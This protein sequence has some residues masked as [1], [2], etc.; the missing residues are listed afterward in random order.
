MA[1]SEVAAV[2]FHT[3]T[4]HGAHLFIP[5][6][7][8]A[9]EDEDAAPYFIASGFAE[10][11]DEEPLM[12]YPQSSVDVDPETIFGSGPRVGQKVMGD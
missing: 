12:T 10:A 11:T 9:F 2:K 5:G 1:D 8:L 7:A 3:P 6:V 4:K